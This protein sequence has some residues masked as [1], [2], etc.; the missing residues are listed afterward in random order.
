MLVEIVKK[1]KKK[2]GNEKTF[3]C[4]CVFVIFGHGS[5]LNFGQQPPECFGAQLL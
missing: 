4:V 1:K 3:E 5:H 2:K